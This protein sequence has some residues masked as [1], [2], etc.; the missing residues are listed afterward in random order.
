MGGSRVNLTPFE[1]ETLNVPHMF[2]ET[3]QQH[4]RRLGDAVR[5]LNAMDEPFETLRRD[6]AI[7]R[8]PGAA[9]PRPGAS[10]EA[11]APGLVFNATK[12]TDVGRIE[13]DRD[14]NR[15]KRMRTTVGHAARLIDF[16]AGEGGRRMRKKFWTLTYRDVDGW[17]PNHINEFRRRVAQWCKRKG[18]D[19]RYVWVSELQQRGAVHYHV[20]VWVPQH[21]RVPYPDKCGW[22]THGST[23]T[24]DVVSPA[25]YLAKYASKTTADMS[26]RYPKGARMHGHGGIDLESRRHLRYWRAPFWVRDGLGGRSDIR[27]VVG[28]YADKRTG[29]FLASPWAV[30]VEAGGRVFAYLKPSTRVH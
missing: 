30:S 8:M 17:E 10:G 13:I 24:K 23:N 14:R 25:S 7:A 18:I 6:Q 4:A 3:P 15:I 27:K 29:E 2:G 20:V 11:A 19:F 16:A 9:K 5:V 22:W 21:I 12:G 1:R 28:G 26:A